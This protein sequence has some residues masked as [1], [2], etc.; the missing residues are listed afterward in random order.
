MPEIDLDALADVLDEDTL[1]AIKAKMAPDVEGAKAKRDLALL[2]NTELK[3]ANPRAFAA[4]EKGLFDLGDVTDLKA[5]EAAIAAKEAEY[6]ALGVPVPGSQPATTPAPPPDPTAALGSMMGG[7]PAPPQRDLVR[8][9][10]EA[11]SENTEEGR[12]RMATVLAEMNNAGM[13]Q[14]ILDLAT[15]VGARP[16]QN[17]LL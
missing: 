14:E 3:A 6:T 4:L 16:K 12:E 17:Q 10:L 1:N 8:E 5:V 7:Q 9:Y 13:K 2:R 11:R 15:R